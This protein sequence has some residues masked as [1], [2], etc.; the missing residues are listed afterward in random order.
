MVPGQLGQAGW[1]CA[2]AAQG[3]ILGVPAA[4]GPATVRGGPPACPP[5]LG[6]RRAE[7]EAPSGLWS[8]VPTRA[9]GA[10]CP[11]W[12]WSQH[13]GPPPG[14]R[15]SALRPGR[16]PGLQPESMS[17]PVPWQERAEQRPSSWPGAWPPPTCSDL[18]L[19]IDDVLTHQRDR[20][21]RLLPLHAP[22][23][24]RGRRQRL[25]FL[26]HPRGRPVGF[27]KALPGP[28]VRRLRLF[29]LLAGG[30]WMNGGTTREATEQNQTGSGERQESEQR[31]R[32]LRAERW[33]MGETQ[34]QSTSRCGVGTRGRPAVGAAARHRSL[35]RGL[36]WEAASVPPLPPDSLPPAQ[37]GPL[38]C[39]ALQGLA[40]A[41]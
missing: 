22:Q 35:G 14:R 27:P 2:A 5:A 1:P 20:G 37:E 38:A 17:V 34:E 6:W 15:P 11:F 39:P 19:E 10:S 9:A 21:A 7:S 26:L 32:G 31:G 16:G 13:C 18:S 8:P 41:R 28:L 30:R 12:L 36:P 23:L 3:G 4:S 25:Q 24:Q 33:G 29:W 40:W